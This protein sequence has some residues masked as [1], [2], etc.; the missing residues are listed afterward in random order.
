VRKRIAGA[1]DGLLSNLVTAGDPYWSS[2]SR[3][4]S[5]AGV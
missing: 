5:W 1:T 3:T 4:V 2:M